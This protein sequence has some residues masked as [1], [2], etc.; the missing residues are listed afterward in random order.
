MMGAGAFVY[1]AGTGYAGQP[2]GGGGGGA[3]FTTSQFGG[4]AGSN[5]VIFFEW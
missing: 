2:Y 3:G 1:P 4:G 5:G